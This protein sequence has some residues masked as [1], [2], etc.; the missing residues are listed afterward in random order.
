MIKRL[1]L[2][3]ALL[4]GCLAPQDSTGVGNP[5]LTTQ[6]QA[7]VDDGDEGTKTG[8]AASSIVSIPM[9]ALD[10]AMHLATELNAATRAKN[11][12]GIYF[13]TTGCLTTVQDMNKV[14]FTF[15]DCTGRFGLAGI[16]GQMTATYTVAGAGQIAIAIATVK[17]FTVEAIG[18]DLRP[19]NAE[20]TLTASALI[21]F[22]GVTRRI[23]W[24]GDYTA[25]LPTFTISHQPTY[26]IVVDTSSGCVAV[27]GS[28]ITNGTKPNQVDTTLTGYKRCGPKNA[29]PLAG[30]KVTFTRKADGAQ[31]SIEFLGGTAA[32]VTGPKRPPIT[33]PGL[34]KCV[35]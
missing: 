10:N 5:G 24:N 12:T 18:R 31:L 17:P 3:A 2:T 22:D 9:L 14:T 35:P 16:N 1:L 15:K 27:D 13:T 26:D 20:I 34:L 8:D 33:L 11:A 19:L 7:L 29:C 23:K 32:K 4:T 6:E 28:S 30:G 25:T 21:A